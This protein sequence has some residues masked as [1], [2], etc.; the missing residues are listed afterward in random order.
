MAEQILRIYDFDQTIYDGN[1]T[2]DFFLFYLK[3]HPLS[4]IH[5]PRQFFT[6]LMESIGLVEEHTF[7]KNVFYILKGAKNLDKDINDFWYIN[8]SKIKAFYLEQK[9]P[10]DI[11][12]SASPEFLLLPMCKKLG[13]RLIATRFD[14]RKLKCVGKYCYGQEKLQRL[15]QIG[16]K[17]CDEF[18]T[19]SMLDSPLIRISKRG[20][21]VEKEKIS[22]IWVKSKSEKK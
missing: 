7:I 20:Y 5:L 14:T 10:N 9:S 6:L 17:E 19:D 15:K 22:L 13:V 8:S 21:K 11:I 4:W 16:I 12:I 18:Y 3:R 1:S 2:K